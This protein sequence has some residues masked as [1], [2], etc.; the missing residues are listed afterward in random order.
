MDKTTSVLAALDAAKF[1]D[2]KQINHAIGW[3][4][5]NG[6]PEIEPAGGGELSAQGKAIANGL[7]EVLQAYKQLGLNKNSQCSCFVSSRPPPPL[8]HVIPL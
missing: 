4:L 1:P 6:I 3:M 5:V 7:R 2:Q 8:K